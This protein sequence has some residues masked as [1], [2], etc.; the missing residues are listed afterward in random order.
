MTTKL[1]W[2]AALLLSTT[3][4][5][6]A[7]APAPSTATPPTP[8]APPAAAS[9]NTV[10]EATASSPAPMAAT[11]TAKLSKSDRKFIMT[12]A[13]AGMAEVQAAQLAEQKSQDATVKEFAQK[14]ITDHTA[15]NKQLASLAE[16]KGITVPT[17]L[18]AKDQK[19]LDALAKLDGTKF[20]KMYLK[21]QVRDHE[22][23]LKLMQKE[24][25]D[26]KDADLKSFAETTTPVI[27]QHLDMAKQDASSSSGKSM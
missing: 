11:S 23:V 18:E 12:A 8:A 2:A 26:G 27:Q 1:A 7:Q 5:A 6:N 17:T 14:M 15:N 22:T 19:Q 21:D 13:S 16:Q 10:P 24:A 20:D 25:A 9:T 3:L 4:A